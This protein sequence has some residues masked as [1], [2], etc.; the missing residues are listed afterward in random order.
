MHYLIFYISTQQN[1]YKRIASLKKQF[2]KKV[3]SCGEQQLQK[4]TG[5]KSSQFR[6]SS[7]ATIIWK[8]EGGRGVKIIRWLWN[9]D[10][11]FKRAIKPHSNSKYR[12][13]YRIIQEGS[14]ETIIKA[15]RYLP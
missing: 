6:I 11:N 2:I 8:F 1:E 15:C 10:I 9:K 7:H 4:L 14:F 5:I 13:R 3:K 12:G